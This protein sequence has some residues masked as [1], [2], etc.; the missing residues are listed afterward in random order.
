MKANKN[1]LFFMFFL[2]ELR[3]KEFFSLGNVWNTRFFKTFA[4]S[5][6]KTGNFFPAR[7]GKKRAYRSPRFP[8]FHRGNGRNR[9][10]ANGVFILFTSA[11]K[12]RKTDKKVT[13]FRFFSK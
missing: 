4:H 5:F 12:S 1:A 13:A 11:R 7:N 8:K 6:P 9:A 10:R 3:K 2:L